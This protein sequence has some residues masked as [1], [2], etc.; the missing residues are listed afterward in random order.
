MGIFLYID[1]YNLPVMLKLY[2]KMFFTNL[3]SVIFIKKLKFTRSE[4]DF[5]I[6]I[7]ETG[8]QAIFIRKIVN[9]FDEFRLISVYVIRHTDRKY[10]KYMQCPNVYQ[11][12]SQS[13]PGVVYTGTEKK[14]FYFHISQ[15]WLL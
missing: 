11:C 12:V 6:H 2:S 9:K 3:I 10:C 7:N 1:T 5:I 8:S 4:F 15:N 13:I 14:K